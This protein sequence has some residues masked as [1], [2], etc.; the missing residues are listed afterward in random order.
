[1]DPP[2]PALSKQLNAGVNISCAKKS[3]NYPEIGDTTLLWG[4]YS[5]RTF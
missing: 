4:K 3:G 2:P 1:M 5:R